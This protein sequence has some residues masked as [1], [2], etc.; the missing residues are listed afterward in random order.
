[1]PEHDATLVELVGRPLSDIRVAYIENAYDVDDDEAFLVEAGRPSAYAGAS[2]SAVVA[3]PTR[4]HFDELDD[5]AEAEQVIWDGLSLTNFV[6]A[7]RGRRELRD[8]F[9]RVRKNAYQ[10]ARGLEPAEAAVLVEAAERIAAERAAAALGRAAVRDAADARTVVRS[11]AVVVGAFSGARLESILA[12][13]AL[14][15]AAEGQLFQEALL[16]GAE[17]CEPEPVGIP[18]QSIPGRVGARRRPR[19]AAALDRPAAASDR[20]ALGG[21]PEAGIESERAGPTPR[22]VRISHLM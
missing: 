13:H 4:R 5:P 12:S 15:H 3:G 2:A 21:G 9:R 14:A 16:Q 1:M 6:V 19:R 11:C 10:A 7:L 17:S 8:P 18:K 20:A 22:R